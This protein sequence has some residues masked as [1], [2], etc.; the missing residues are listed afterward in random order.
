MP[1]RTTNSKQFYQFHS[2]VEPT[3][4]RCFVFLYLDLEALLS[5]QR[6]SIGHETA[7]CISKDK[8]STLFPDK[9]S[10]LVPVLYRRLNT[11]HLAS[12]HKNLMV[13]KEGI[14]NEPC[15]KNQPLQDQPHT[16]NSVSFKNSPKVE[17]R[18][19]KY[20]VHR[21]TQRQL[22]L[23]LTQN[24]K[25]PTGKREPSLTVVTRL[26][27]QES[28]FYPPIQYLSCN[29]YTALNT[30]QRFYIQEPYI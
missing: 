5:R 12:V 26:L 6:C 14:R 22:S 11:T 30:T 27:G 21:Y 18:K 9:Y 1:L 13:S 23:H 16:V 2:T 7:T 8:Y 29:T 20:T 24:T 15:I 28:Y 10:T 3:S 17:N 4:G 25:N 19:A